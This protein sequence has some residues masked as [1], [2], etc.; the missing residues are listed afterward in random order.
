VEIILRGETKKRPCYPQNLIPSLFSSGSLGTRG[1]D[2]LSPYLPFLSL[3]VVGKIQHS[4][5]E[6]HRFGV[7]QPQQGTLELGSSRPSGAAPDGPQHLCRSSRC[8]LWYS[9]RQMVSGEGELARPL[10][11]VPPTPSVLHPSSLAPYGE[12]GDAEL[13]T[14]SLPCSTFLPHYLLHEV[15]GSRRARILGSCGRVSS[16]PAGSRGC[17]LAGVVRRVVPAMSSGGRH[18]RRFSSPPHARARAP[19]RMGNH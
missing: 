7:A 3:V 8:W 18:R 12:G 5:R 14:A 9:R 13:A 6:E 2:S 11:P 19:R 10:P 16:S 17:G 4:H 1:C 15:D